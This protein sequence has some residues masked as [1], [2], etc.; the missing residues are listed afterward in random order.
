M[1]VLWLC[2][3]ILPQI[4]IDLKLPLEVSGGWLTGL[5]E[6]LEGNTQVE[7]GICFPLY[8]ENRIIIGCLKNIKYYG[9]PKKKAKPSTYEK[10]IEDYFEA[11]ILDFKPDIIHIFGTEYPHTLAMIKK[12]EQIHDIDKVIISIQGLVSF[13]HKHYMAMLPCNIWHKN[14]IRDFIK[15]ENLTQCRREFK[16]RGQYEIKALQKV[17]NVIGRTEWDKACVMQIN[18]KLNYYVCNEILRNDFYLHNW[19]SDKCEKY[20]IFMSQGSYPIKGL[21]FMLE[22]MPEILLHYPNTKLYIAGSDITSSDTIKDRMK[23]TTYGKYIKK[24]VL[25]YKLQRSVF[26]TGLLNSQKMCNRFLVSNV[27]VSPS[28][29][30]NSS[31]S[32]GEAMLLG[33]PTIS[34]DVGG[35]KNLISHGNEGFIYQFDAPYMLA[36]YIKLIFSDDELA[37][38][39]SINA[40]HKAY[41]IYNKANNSD[42]LIKIYKR[43]LSI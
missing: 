29:I 6:S 39:I 28:A 41:K 33:V 9:F 30:E 35:V 17:K 5:L 43:L 38:R 20:S 23:I 13:I 24:L 32:I 14:T 2:N 27:F 7:L 37:R 10:E 4:S 22:A 3:I 1:K 36:Y 18:N 21:H 31:N 42:T 11:I 26:F 8:Y 16:L 40:K 19:E 12:C 15:S 25:K 34:S